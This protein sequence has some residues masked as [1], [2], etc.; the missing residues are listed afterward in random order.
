[1]SKEDQPAS[2]PPTEAVSSDDV[3]REIRTSSPTSQDEHRHIIG[4]KRFSIT[5]LQSNLSLDIDEHSIGSLSVSEEGEH[6]HDEE[7]EEGESSPRGSV[8]GNLTDEESYVVSTSGSEDE[9]DTKG[10]TKKG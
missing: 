3:P 1:M 9:E 8:K 6:E 5:P 10:S 7:E 2:L 4:G